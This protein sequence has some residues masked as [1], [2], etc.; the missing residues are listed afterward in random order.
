VGGGGGAPA[1]PPPRHTLLLLLFVPLA[2]AAAVTVA[3]HVAGVWGGD[4]A[5]HLYKI[6]LLREGQSIFWDNDWYGGS[7]Q[8]VTYGF[9]Y[10]WLARWVGAELLVV[11]SSGVMPILFYL[12]MR[13]VYG[14]TTYLP[15]VA[16]CGT[17]LLYLS[18]GQDPFLFA[19]ALMMAGLVLL[20]YGR[21]AL[22]VVPVALA[23]FANP[24]AVIV[25]GIF[26]V[27]QAVSEKDRR[28]TILRFAVY[29]SPFLAA[30]LVLSIVFS[31]PATYTFGGLDLLI[32]VAYGVIGATAA[33]MSADPRRRAKEILFVTFAVAVVLTFLVPGNPLG[34]NVGRFVRIFGLPLL[35]CLR[36][37]P[38]RKS[39][40]VPVLVLIAAYTVGSPARQFVLVT[41]ETPAQEMFFAPA[42]DFANLHRDPDY[43]SHV[44][45]L[46]THWEAYYFSINDYAI[47]RGWYRQDDALHN[48]VLG[49]DDF[50][51][52]QYV[53]WL[54]RM[55]VKY[56]YLPHAA[57]DTSGARETEILALSPEFTVVHD[58]PQWTIYRLRDAE[59]MIAPGRG[60]G[61]GHI[62]ALEHQ[63]I[64]L[65]VTAPGSY[66]IKVTYSP[67]WEVT[68][69]AGRLREGPNGFLVLR[70]P[71]A[72][73]YGLRVNVTL[74]SS[75]RRFLTAL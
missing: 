60:A 9:V 27:A 21:P 39:V 31:K 23:M 6:D 73:Y 41:Q 55:G 38:L 68:A 58:D 29:L 20:A 50:T 66:L 74:G 17:L 43:R 15:A 7:Y 11:A 14:V 48:D 28:P 37:V 46:D 57:L 51:A 63:S 40:A 70:A 34:G 59:P 71:K 36:D 62:L 32:F 26:L 61:E 47:T 19:L 2:L 25:A 16:L 33:R 3:M 13:R 49:S 42:L 56:V 24:V 69:G 5:A 64:Y 67:Y 52:R 44:V 30:R 12:Y 1:P 54:R 10:Y 45:A 53:N 22:A 8:I 65:E 75:I 4:A 35:L 72:G 18:W